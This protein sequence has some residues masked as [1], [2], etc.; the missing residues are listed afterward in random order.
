[1]TAMNNYEPPTWGGSLLPGM[2]F[3]LQ[4]RDTENQVQFW[5]VIYYVSALSQ[6][7]L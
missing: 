2:G 1:M 5:A 3:W 4:E 7:G 6:Q